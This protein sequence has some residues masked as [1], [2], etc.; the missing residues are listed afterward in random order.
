[1]DHVS[2]ANF[3]KKWRSLP[4]LS[5][6]ASLGPIHGAATEGPP[7]TLA[8]PGLDPRSTECRQSAR[9]QS[10]EHGPRR[11]VGFVGFGGFGGLSCFSTQ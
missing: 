8:A 6:I 10:M 1:M 7:W 11:V 2:T 3:F 9:R 4:G 5:R